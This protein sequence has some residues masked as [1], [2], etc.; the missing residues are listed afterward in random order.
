MPIDVGERAPAFSLIDQHG[1][2]VGSEDLLGGKALVVFIPL[3]FSAVCEAELCAVRDNLSGLNDLDA[4]VVVITCDTWLVNHAWAEQQG[5]AFPVLSD[6]WPHGEV[7]RAFGTF[8]EK[9]GTARRSTFVLDAG[10]VV[11]RV[12]TS[13]PFEPRPFDQY[14]DALA[15]L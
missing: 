3:P 7:S 14:V 13:G 11:R 2:T 9:S 10:G 4:R 12:I 1:Q 15:E 8:S 6:F 5:F